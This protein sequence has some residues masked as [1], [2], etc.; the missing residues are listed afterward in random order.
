MVGRRGRGRALPPPGTPPL[1]LG[2]PAH[3]CL[4]PPPFPGRLSAGASGAQ[5]EPVLAGPGAGGGG[6]GSTGPWCSLAKGGCLSR[7]GI[8]SS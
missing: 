5:R 6:W 4:P 7:L 2:L 1:T 8:S 3:L